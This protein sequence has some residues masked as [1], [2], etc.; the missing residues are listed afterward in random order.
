MTDISD[1]SEKLVELMWRW[2]G[3]LWDNSAE[4]IS[5]QPRSIDW[6]PGI[7]HM[8]IAGTSDTMDTP[9]TSDTIDTVVTIVI[10]L[11]WCN[12]VTSYMKKQPGIHSIIKIQLNC[13]WCII[14]RFWSTLIQVIFVWLKQLCV[15]LY[16]V[17]VPCPLGQRHSTLN[18]EHNMWRL[19]KETVFS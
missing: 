19:H 2:G 8:D 13:D 1:L 9:G 14:C 12:V 18:F 4:W 5:K 17:L 10:T 11:K 16:A 7:H 15:F 6:G 3:Y